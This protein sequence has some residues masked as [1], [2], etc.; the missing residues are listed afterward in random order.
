LPRASSHATDHE[1]RDDAQE[2]PYAQAAGA[3]GGDFAVGSE[4]AESDED[5]DQHAHG[6]GVGE[7][8]RD[9]EEKDFRNAG[10]RG[11]VA[12]D[13]FEDASEVAGEQDESENGRADQRVGDDFSQ[14][15]AGEDAHPQG[16]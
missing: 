7:R 3:H 12:D 2:G 5:A 9:G 8:D 15:V 1:N 10:Q 4:T 6:N 11:A 16:W 14:N 13:Q